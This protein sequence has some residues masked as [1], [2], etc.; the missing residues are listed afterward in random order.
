MLAHHVIEGLVFVQDFAIKVR[1]VLTL[2]VLLALVGVLCVPN[3]IQ[4]GERLSRLAIKEAARSVNEGSQSV[5]ALLLVGVV[6]G[7][8]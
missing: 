2:N 7:V 4:V 6:V 5:G 8:F 3:S 1:E